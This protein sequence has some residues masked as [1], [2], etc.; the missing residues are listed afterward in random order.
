MK[1]E[2]HLE[3]RRK[4]IATWDRKCETSGDWLGLYKVG[5]YSNAKYMQSIYA[6]TANSDG[7][8][9]FEAPREPG[10]YEVRYFF[11]SKKQGSGYAYSGKSEEIIVKN[12][13]KLEVEATHPIVKVHWQ[14]FS[15]EPHGRD[16]IGVFP[17]KEDGARPLGW[18]YLS[19][20][21]LLD[22]V[23]DH[24]IAEIEV[25]VLMNLSEQATLPEEAKEWEVRL[26]NQ[27]PQQPHL[28]IPFLKK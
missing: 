12:E 9:V 13:D 11:T 17:N 15:Q 2:A 1:V 26:Y 22:T 24:G 20:K 4:I 18:E 23:G 14:T 21:G 7:Q 3:G 28:R 5:T 8:V 10:K 25:K 6:S 27:A 16:W 19:K